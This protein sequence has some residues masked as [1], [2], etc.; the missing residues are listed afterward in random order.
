MEV[1]LSSSLKGE[2]NIADKD[3]LFQKILSSFSSTTKLFEPTVYL[4][5]FM[6][7]SFIKNTL[8]YILNKS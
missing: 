1:T 2:V 6:V 3:F 7:K 4:L 5:W 8:P